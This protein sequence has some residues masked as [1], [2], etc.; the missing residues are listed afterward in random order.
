[1]Q[2]VDNALTRTNFIRTVDHG[3]IGWIVSHSQLFITAA[4]ITQSLT[5]GNYRFSRMED[6]SLALLL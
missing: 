2:N 4:E 3:G 1:M 5:I 6:G